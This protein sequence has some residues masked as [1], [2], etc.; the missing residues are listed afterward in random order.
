MMDDTLRQHVIHE[1]DKIIDERDWPSIAHALTRQ[2]RQVVSA[3]PDVEILGAP[4]S[5]EKLGE[6]R[7]FYDNTDTSAE[8]KSAQV[9]E[10]L[11]E[12]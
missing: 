1:L 8:I 3:W 4:Y 6:L 7:K 10:E 11:G 9:A 2:L 5:E 12:L